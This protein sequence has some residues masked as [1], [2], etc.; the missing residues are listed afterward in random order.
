MRHALSQGDIMSF[1]SRRV[2][3]LARVG[4]VVAAVLLLGGTRHL[5]ATRTVNRASPSD[6]PVG[7]Q[8]YSFRDAFKTDV[9]GTL[10]HIRALGF[11]EVE[12]AGTYGNTARQ[13]RRMLDSAGLRA[14]SMHVGYEQFHDSLPAVLADAKTLGVHYVGTAWIPHPDGPITVAL[15]KEAAANFTRWGR[16]AREQGFQFFYHAHGYEFKRGEGGVLPMD[17]IMKETDPKAVAF[18]M[19]VFWMTLPGNNPVALLRQYRGRWKLMHLKDMKKGV[20]TNVLTGSA[21]PNA[22]EVPVGTGQIDYKA[23]IKTAKEVGVKEFY[24]EDETVAPFE[25]VPLSVSWLR[26]IKF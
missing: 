3:G 6:A 25:T 23:V 5:F 1:S 17:L 21:D 9:P 22:T 18:E 4:L 26:S 10:A 11:K 16:A 2:T 12:L 15:A 19:D 14:T 13:F 7:V 8:L 20:A 24:L